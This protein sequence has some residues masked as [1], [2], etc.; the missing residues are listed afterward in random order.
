LN[1]T[2]FLTGGTGF[3]GTELASQLCGSDCGKV[4]V[5]VRAENEAA[6]MH[7]LKS[8]WFPMRGLYERIGVQFF[9]VCGDFTKDSLGLTEADADMLRESVTLVIHSGA[10]IGFQKSR[11]E[12]DTVN[13][14]GTRNMLSF[15]AGLQKLRLFVHIS[16]AY[17]AGQRTV[18]IS[19]TDPLGTAFSGYSE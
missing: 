4:Y 2:I 18:L 10:E 12:L 17:V 8:A 9:P 14:L 3:L 5:L 16:T 11:R 13:R 15:A 1:E 7:R 19:V 6:A